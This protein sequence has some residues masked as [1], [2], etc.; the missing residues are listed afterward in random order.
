MSIVTVQLGQCGNQIGL[1]LFDN[2]FND[3]QAGHRTTF[4]TASWERFF[5]QSQHGDFVARAVLI[6]MEPKVI[7]QNLSRPTKWKYEQASSFNQR[8]GCGNNWADGFC[9]QGPAHSD[10]MENLVR[11]Q[12]ERCERLSGFLPVMS[13]A[14]GTGSGV[15]TFVTQRLR[16]SYPKSFL[17]NHLTWPYS[18]GETVVQN[19]NSL[20]TLRHVYQLSD[21]L[22]VQEN[23]V[24]HRICGQLLRLKHV[25]V[26][27]INKVIAHHLGAVLQPALTADSHGVYSRN[28]LGELVSCLASHCE[29]RLL[30]ISSVPHI[31]APS[32]A[33]STF[34][35]PVMLKHLRQMLASSSK[36][37]EGNSRQVCER[38]R[39]L[40]GSPNVSLANLL[41]LR[42][43]DVFTTE[44]GDFGDAALYSDWLAPK[45]ALSVW[46]SPV[47]F[48][49]YEKTA[50]LVSNSQA[51]M[52]PLD[53]IVRK[54]WNLFA[55][56]AFI[57]HYSKFGVSEEDFLDSFAFV[58]QI[59]SS[60][61]QLGGNT[62]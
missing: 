20:L 50:T 32:M 47:A 18:Q 14:G 8:Q 7:R 42:G 3:C 55:S 16:D 38:P 1:E 23:D 48:N 13:V 35:W 59:L 4:S 12:V 53:H 40:P 31:P 57:H 51:L 61:G 21:A 45:D 60:Y 11:R 10:V 43:K 37:E 36:M 44:T 24:V 6:D 41:V 5:H 25:S 58:E 29:Y 15:G 27:H 62:S 9:V 56:R 19:Y 39:R 30:S 28:P 34:H 26:N 54:A 46:K 33:Y 49:K 22:L 2:I 52:E 17:V